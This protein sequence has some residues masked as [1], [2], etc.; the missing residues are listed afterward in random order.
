MLTFV[1][2]LQLVKANVTQTA[3]YN[4]LKQVTPMEH[5]NFFLLFLG[6]FFV[7]ISTISP[8]NIKE[9]TLLELVEDQS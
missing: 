5:F 1:F 4:H 2:Y 7:A 6:G 3:N 8:S 9:D